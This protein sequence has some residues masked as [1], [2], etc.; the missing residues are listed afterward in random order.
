M[1]FFVIGV[2]LFGCAVQQTITNIG[3]YSI[4][5]LRPHFIDVCKPNWTAI[6]CQDA[7]GNFIYV[8]DAFCTGT[9]PRLI[10]EM[11]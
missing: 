10:K 2:F 1:T 6:N 8:Q 11:R 7:Q 4:G 3:K 9:E 5:R